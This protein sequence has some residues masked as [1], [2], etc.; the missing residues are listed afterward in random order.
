MS[1]AFDCLF[2]VVEEATRELRDAESSAHH[3]LTL[4]RSPAAGR[5]QCYRGWPFYAL[6]SSL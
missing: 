2:G 4:T 6:K 1:T 5:F 3:R